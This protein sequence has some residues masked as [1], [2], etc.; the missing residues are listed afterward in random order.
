MT[1]KLKTVDFDYTDPEG[2]TSYFRHRMGAVLKSAVQL[3]AF[4]NELEDICDKL[5]FNQVQKDHDY[6]SVLLGGVSGDGEYQQGSLAKFYNHVFGLSFEDLDDA[7]YKIHQDLPIDTPVQVTQTEFTTFIDEVID[8]I[9]LILQQAQ[10]N[11]G[12]ETLD[13]SITLSKS[14]E[15][16]KSEVYNLIDNPDELLELLS[17]FLT[18]L[19]AIVP[20]ANERALFLWTLE[21]TPQYYLERAYPRLKDPESTDSD[22]AT[23]EEVWTLFRDL[24][25]LESKFTPD[26]QVDSKE[27]KQLQQSYT[28]Y[29]YWEG[30]LGRSILDL[31]RFVWST[32]DGELT[33]DLKTGLRS[34]PNFKRDFRNEVDKQL[35]EIGWE[36]PDDIYTVDTREHGKE[37]IQAQTTVVIQAEYQIDGLMLPT[38]EYTTF[39]WDVKG[40]DEY[41]KNKQTK[42]CTK[43]LTGFFDSLAPGLFLLHGL[44]WELTIDEDSVEI[45]DL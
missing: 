44:D 2:W 33:D 1:Q 10:D 8:Q 19:Q 16:T 24:F 3:K 20:H 36:F 14:P 23:S 43:P 31:Y 5:P 9:K 21:L 7:I 18:N 38:C 15:L 17:E 12:V 25:G 34:V 40:R 11:F 35:H 41:S 32:F 39:R 26:I 13:V 22:T 42:K 37:D 4:R 6:T 28:L 27:N 29:S 45:I 30:S